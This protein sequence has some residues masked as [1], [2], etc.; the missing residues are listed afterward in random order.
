VLSK[1]GEP[2][3]LPYLGVRTLD[4]DGLL[5]VQYVKIKG[6]CSYFPNDEILYTKGIKLNLDHYCVG[7][8]DCGGIFLVLQDDI[9]ISYPLP[10][11]KN[12]SLLDNVTSI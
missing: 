5:P 4:Q 2:I 6:I 7:I 12:L 10:Q 3:R 11:K 8:Y 9:P 1:Y